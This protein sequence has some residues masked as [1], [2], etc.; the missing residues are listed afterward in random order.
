[1]TVWVPGID[2]CTCLCSVSHEPSEGRLRGCVEPVAVV[3]IVIAA[4]SAAEPFA[5]RH[6]IDLPMCCGCAEAWA[7]TNPRFVRVR[8]FGNP[9][10][11]YL[12]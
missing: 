6:T 10:Q 1:V 7:A 4:G 5:P 12:N 9:R 11:A 8:A 3:V 2:T